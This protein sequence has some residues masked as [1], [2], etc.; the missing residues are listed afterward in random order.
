M[1]KSLAVVFLL[2]IVSGCETMSNTD[3]GILGG[4]AIGAGLGAAA[5][6]LS[7]HAG[8]GALIGGLGGA[9]IGGLAGHAE[10]EYQRE[11][12]R[13]AA[14]AAAT[15]RPPLT[16]M[17]IVH[18]THQHIS[19]DTIINQIRTTNSVYNVTAEDV[20]WLKQQGVSDRVLA[21]IQARRPGYV[22]VPP[23]VVYPPPAYVVE[24]SPV[25]VGIGFGW[26]T[27][28]CWR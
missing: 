4:G 14:L 19:D 9:L 5:G 11:Q 23:A 13:A 2:I 27:G 24:E 21:E 26:S 1:R 8:A 12:R 20:I 15:A 16:L 6:S 22:Y 25:H 7:G 17:D 18:M 10:D 3:K 28:R